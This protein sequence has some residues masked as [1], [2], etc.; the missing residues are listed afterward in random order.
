MKVALC[1]MEILWENKEENLLKAEHYIE[2]A[3]LQKSDVVFFPEM[4]LTGFSMN[5]KKTGEDSGYTVKKI[6]ELALKYGIAI[7]IGWVNLKGQKGENHY[8][9]VNKNGVV[10][11][12][13]IKIHPFS[14]ADENE[15]FER[16]E[17]ITTFQLKNVKCSNFICYDLR[18]PEIFQ[19]VST[20]TEVIIVPANWPEKRREHWMCLL[21][22]RAIENQVYMIGINCVGNIGGLEYSGDSCVINPE[23]ECIGR[24]SRQEGL[25]LCEIKDDVK[26]YRSGFPV[27]NDRRVEYYKQIL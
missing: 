19:A 14:Y 26:G 15:Y 10:V 3:A 21:K 7:G 16:G 20:E 24:L 2:Q 12:D 18:F 17:R 9:I 25:I 1:Q 5:I 23:G 11:D 6:A 13:Y 8:T 27:K 4:S 22:A